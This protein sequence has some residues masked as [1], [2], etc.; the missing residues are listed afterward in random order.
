ML[1]LGRLQAGYGNCD[2]D[3]HSAL[4]TRGIMIFFAKP[5]FQRSDNKLLASNSQTLANALY[6]YLYGPYS[7]PRAFRRASYSN[8]DWAPRIGGAFYTLWCDWCCCKIHCKL[9]FT[10]PSFCSVREQDFE[11]S[12]VTTAWKGELLATGPKEITPKVPCKEGSTI[13]VSVPPTRVRLTT[14]WRR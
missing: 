4:V 6:P 3:K 8:S 13:G 12:D 11:G 14:R 1:V 9:N 2:G 5:N 7:H 10:W